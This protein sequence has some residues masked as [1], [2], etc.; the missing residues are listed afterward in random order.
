MENEHPMTPLNLIVSCKLYVFESLIRTDSFE[1][2]VQESGYTASAAC[3]LTH[4][5][6]SVQESDYTGCTTGFLIH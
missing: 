4:K 1:S 3:F 6:E 5:K 2:F